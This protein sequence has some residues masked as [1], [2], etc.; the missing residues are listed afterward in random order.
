MALNNV[1]CF[2]RE[3]IEFPNRKLEYVIR[4]IRDEKMDDP[5]VIL[6][7]EL[8]NRTKETTKCL[9][10]DI[11]IS[12][13]N[14]DYKIKELEKKIITLEKEIE[15]LNKQNDVLKEQTIIDRNTIHKMSHYNSLLHK[16]IPNV[17][18]EEYSSESEDEDFDYTKIQVKQEVEEEEE[19]EKVSSLDKLEFYKENRKVVFIEFEEK[20]ELFMK[21][22]NEEEKKKLAKLC[23]KLQKRVD[24]YDFRI[25]NIMDERQK[26]LD[27]MAVFV[28]RNIKIDSIEKR[29]KEAQALA[30][31]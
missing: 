26:D 2:I 30:E 18:N 21:E 9:D 29:E 23:K 16:Q 27:E 17:M 19:E 10:K 22:K 15:T 13:K 7:H 31:M 8:Y 24:E 6:C 1:V 14:M 5:V 20:K 25:Q 4:K 3:N 12:L 28:M 11:K